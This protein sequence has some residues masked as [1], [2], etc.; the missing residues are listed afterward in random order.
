M[1]RGYQPFVLLL[2]VA[3]AIGAITGWMFY[4]SETFTCSGTTNIGVYQRADFERLTDKSGCEK[5]SSGDAFSHGFQIGL[6]AYAFLGFTALVATV[7]RRPPTKG[8]KG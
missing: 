5:I 3:V 7:L 4:Q 8:P 2:I 1:L 6:A